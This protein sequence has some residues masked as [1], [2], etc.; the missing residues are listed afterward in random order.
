MRLVQTE[1]VQTEL[2]NIC[3]PLGLSRVTVV[4]FG[5]GG[6]GDRGTVWHGP[7]ALPGLVITVTPGS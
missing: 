2:A 1:L 5:F 4:K 3:L 7:L 6:Q